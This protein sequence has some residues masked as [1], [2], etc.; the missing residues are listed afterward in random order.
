MLNGLDP[1]MLSRCQIPVFPARF[2]KPGS[3]KK[4][5]GFFEIVVTLSARFFLAAADVF[6]ALAVSKV[7]KSGKW[8]HAVG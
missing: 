2:S 5:I 3:G 7:I 8:V 1:I 4:A 6:E